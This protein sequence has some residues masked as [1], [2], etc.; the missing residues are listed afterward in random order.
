MTTI[1]PTQ[2]R[3]AAVDA[4]RGLALGGMLLVNLGA[5]SGAGQVSLAYLSGPGS[6]ARPD[7]WARM[8]ELLLAE[9]K[10]Y[11]LFAFL[12]G[13]GIARQQCSG[14]PGF[15]WR[16]T[17][18]MVVLALFGLL[19][20][21]LLWPGD[22]LF[23]YACIGLVLPFT[24]GW[25]HKR[26]WAATCAIG[27][28][29][30]LSA[31]WIAPG[32]G[33]AL[34][35]G[36]SSLVAPVSAFLREQMSQAAS[37]VSARL[38]E[39]GLKLVYFPGWLGNFAAL[40][41]AGYAVGG[42]PQY[43]AQRIQRGYSRLIVSLRLY[44][45]QGHKGKNGI[46]PTP[47]TPTTL[48]P[49]IWVLLLALLLNLFY[50]L[51]AASPSGLPVEWAASLR[52]TAL[53]LGGPL[54]ALA[55]AL[56]LACWYHQPAGGQVGR[57]FR[58]GLAGLGRMPLTTYLCQS[59]VGALLFPSPTPQTSPALLWLTAGLIFLAQMLFAHLWLARF[60]RGPLEWAWR[61]LS[62]LI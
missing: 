39:F 42:V 6:W 17:R 5:F 61:R 30:L 43:G 48:L 45:L 13:W 56:G 34:Q 7:W 47:V 23:V 1:P 15:A 37:P 12:F 8:L 40:I 27:S 60:Q 31:L 16:N 24:Q 25:V 55:Y 32:P 26:A 3:I 19:H 53:S 4:V 49:L 50:A 59:A 9:G 21:A 22:I 41:L 52:A 35:E 46:H 58:T 14:G 18:R 51:S 54:L 2:P 10:F 57:A 20:A 36:Y 11:P 44:I 28:L 38:A 62:S 33:R 29:L